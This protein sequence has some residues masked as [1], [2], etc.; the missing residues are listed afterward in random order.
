MIKI[1]RPKCPD[2]NA[3]KTN[4]KHPKN[5]LALKE[6]SADKC[7][8]CESKIGHISFGDVEHIRPKSRY[9][10]LEHE[11]DNLGYVCSICNNQKLDKFHEDAPYIDS[12][13]DQPE[14]HLMGMGAFILQKRGSER[15]EITIKDVSLNRNA[16]VEKRKNK[17]DEVQKAVES[18]FRTKNEAL[19]KDALEQL[20]LEAS[21]DKEY[22]FF[23]KKL[24]QDHGV[25]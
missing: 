15:G 9:P 4:Y 19:R 16:L 10:H 3:L 6:A 21:V 5:K 23:V 7:M 1:S 17:L 22:S 2:P 13:S 8:Y 24:L 14:D 12:Y 18:C 11:W 25:L 20:K